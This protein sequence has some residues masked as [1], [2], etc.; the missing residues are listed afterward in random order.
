MLFTAFTGAATMP[1]HAIGC[2]CAGG[3][4]RRIFLGSAD[5]LRE[6]KDS[7]CADIWH[8]LYAPYVH[9]CSGDGNT[10]AIVRNV[11]PMTTAVT[12][13]F[14]NVV[15]TIARKVDEHFQPAGGATDK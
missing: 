8:S 7:D 12:G 5:T 15:A 6:I 3:T 13:S 10:A 1:A 2:R 9:V 11:W 14:S 4:L